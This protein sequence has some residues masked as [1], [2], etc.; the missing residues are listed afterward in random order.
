MSLSQVVN[1]SANLI[2]YCSLG[3]KFRAQLYRHLLC[4]HFSFS[5]YF[6]SFSSSSFS[7]SSSCSSSFP[8]SSLCS[9]SFSPLLPPH[10][11]PPLPLLPP[12]P[13][14][15]QE[16]ETL[17]SV[18][19]V[20]RRGRP[21]VSQPT[22]ASPSFPQARCARCGL[23][24]LLPDTVGRSSGSGSEA[25]RSSKCWGNRRKYRGGGQ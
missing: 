16:R 6:S 17:L 8:S 14:Q 23:M 21:R 24:R 25:R 11:P 4:R 1:S 20:L 2:I 7:F 9:S 3:T 15:P 10:F 13:P 18:S 5:S 22:S 12:F 19:A